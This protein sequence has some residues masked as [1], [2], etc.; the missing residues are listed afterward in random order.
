M[1]WPYIFHSDLKPLRNKHGACEYCEELPPE[2]VTFR[3][4]A[5][6][7]AVLY[8]SRECQ[9]KDWASHRYVPI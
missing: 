9:R 1:V 5:A 7:K 4:C 3:K 8:C 6:C 2:G